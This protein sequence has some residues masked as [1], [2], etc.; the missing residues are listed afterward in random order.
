MRLMSVLGA[1]LDSQPFICGNEPSLADFAVA[2]MATYFQATDFPERQHSSIAAWLQRMAAIPAWE[3]TLFEPWKRADLEERDEDLSTR[4]RHMTTD[5]L[6]LVL[7][8]ICACFVV[9]FFVAAL[10]ALV[11]GNSM[12]ARASARRG[13][14]AALA[15]LPVSIANAA[16]GVYAGTEPN[17]R[18]MWLA[19]AISET[20]NLTLIVLP[21]GI[22][23][24]TV[25]IIARKRSKNVPASGTAS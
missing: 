11:R 6:V 15:F 24:C 17:S 3:A 9:G 20:M 12:R 25:W 16:A 5:D 19:R 23:S 8:A 1:A 22:A 14:L 13:S 2:G 7:P 10:R 4:R 21:F 18:A